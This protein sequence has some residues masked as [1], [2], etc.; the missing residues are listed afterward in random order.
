ME[1]LP[2]IVILMHLLFQNTMYS[3]GLSCHLDI[4][5]PLTGCMQLWFLR[6]IW[7]NVQAIKGGHTYFLDRKLHLHQSTPAFLQYLS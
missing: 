6:L 4:A 1:L 5:E 3:G 2:H 7:S